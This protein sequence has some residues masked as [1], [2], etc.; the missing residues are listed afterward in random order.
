MR[1]IFFDESKNDP[2][3]RHYHLGAVCID[4]ASLTETEQLV[5]AIA[6]KAFG[7]SRLSR[8]T[9]LHAADIYGRMSNFKHCPD[10]FGKRLDL[11]YDF[12][13][14]LSNN[15]VS[16]IDIQI[17]CDKLYG[18]KDPADV[19]FMYLCERANDFLRAN[20]AVGMLIGDREN[21]QLADQYATT[22]SDYREHGTE[23]E[24][25]RNIENLVD[26][27]HFS[28]SH[29]SRL[30][31]LADAYTWLLQFRNRRQGSTHERHK[32]VLDILARQ[33]IDLG[34]SK[35]KHWPN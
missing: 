20:D 4:E 34:P 13:R 17:N 22:L 5:A 33:D 25:G 3:Y 10:F 27:V 9:E 29:L 15:T 16:L 6:E 24:Y 23:F 18:A 31:Q 12:A 11:L 8:Q 28:H 30:L 7:S 32:A 19:A 1:L 21:D 2:D 35:Y 26:S 14:I